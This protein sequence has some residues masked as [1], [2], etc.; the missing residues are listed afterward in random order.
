MWVSHDHNVSD[1]QAT[2]TYTTHIEVDVKGLKLIARVPNNTHTGK[3]FTCAPVVEKQ[4]KL[5]HVY[6]YHISDAHMYR[7]GGALP[8][9]LLCS[10]PT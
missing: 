2:I 7:E 10:N 9:I 8:K 6:K 4:V 5:L 1:S 3:V